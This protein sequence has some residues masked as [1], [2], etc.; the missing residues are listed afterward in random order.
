MDPLTLLISLQTKINNFN[1][2]T[3]LTAVIKKFEINH[4]IQQ[5]V[6]MNSNS[7]LSPIKLTTK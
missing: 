5:K 7:N 1:G 3:E 2:F 4:R 6:L